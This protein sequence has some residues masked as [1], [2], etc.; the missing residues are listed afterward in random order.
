MR[1]GASAKMEEDGG[2]IEPAFE[3][4][5]ILVRRPFRGRAACGR[6]GQMQMCAGRP[7]T[8][9]RRPRRRRQTQRA[10]CGMFVAGRKGV[11]EAGANRDAK[12]LATTLGP[13]RPSS[14]RTLQDH[15]ET[16]RWRSSGLL[17]ARGQEFHPLFIVIVCQTGSFGEFFLCVP[18]ALV[19]GGES[20]P[21]E[22]MDG[23]RAREE[24]EV[25][26]EEEAGK[27]MVMVMM[28]QR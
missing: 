19:V 24:E 16:R 5:L 17:P 2:Q 4:R 8:L 3:C 9:R 22:W 21:G 18:Y 11:R 25:G 26:E 28:M 23:G 1:A 10:P 27:M 14:M 20:G 12:C 13:A 7:A 15:D 6:A